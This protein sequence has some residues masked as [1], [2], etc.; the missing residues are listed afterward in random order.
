M[1]FNEKN[2][3]KVKKKLKKNEKIKFLKKMMQ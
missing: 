2:G 1:I 3:K